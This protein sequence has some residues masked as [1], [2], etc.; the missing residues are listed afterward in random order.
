MVSFILKRIR[1][2]IQP[3]VNCR[4]EEC[5]PHVFIIYRCVRQGL[6]IVGGRVVRVGKGLVMRQGRISVNRLVCHKFHF[7]GRYDAV[8]PLR[9]LAFIFAA[10]DVLFYIIPFRSFH[11]VLF[12]LCHKVFHSTMLHGYLIEK[13]F[14]FIIYFH[15]PQFL[16]QV[17]AGLGQLVVDRA[18]LCLPRGIFRRQPVP[19]RLLPRVF[20]GPF[21][22]F[23][24]FVFLVPL[25]PVPDFFFRYQLPRFHITLVPFLVLLN[26]SQA[27]LRLRRDVVC[28]VFIAGIHQAFPCRRYYADTA[29]VVNAHIIQSLF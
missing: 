17:L 25:G 8:V 22:T 5:F 29:V 4:F 23:F 28:A 6:S 9:C 10:F 27:V 18:L 3:G 26:Q 1:K 14:M 19:F 7:L 21:R 20:R 24:L 12:I 15:L 16:R 13:S 2:C 11:D